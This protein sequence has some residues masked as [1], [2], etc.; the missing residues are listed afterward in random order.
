MKTTFSFSLALLLTVQ[1][2]GQSFNDSI[3]PAEV[4]K[5]SPAI[6]KLQLNLGSKLIP[7]TIYQ[8][9]NVQEVVCFNMHDN[10]FT[11]VEAAMEVLSRRGGLLIKIENRKQ[12]FITFKLGNKTYTFDANRIFSRKGI[13]QTL[14]ERGR[15]SPAAAVEVDNFAQRLLSLIPDTASCIV[16]LHNNFDAS[17]SIKS[18]VEGGDRQADAREVYEDSLQDADDIALTTDSILYEKMAGFGYNSILQDNMNVK[19]DGSLSVYYGEKETLY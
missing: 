3:V 2:F 13:E 10:E 5:F 18:Y 1:F 12:R 17:F 11:S 9:G 4:S 16:A 7:V 8:Y 19:K 14:R 15:F 6:Q